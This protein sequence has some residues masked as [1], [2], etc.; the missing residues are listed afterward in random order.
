MKMCIDFCPEWREM[1]E[2][3]KTCGNKIVSYV[4]TKVGLETS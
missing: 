2:E 4:I 3:E 1:K